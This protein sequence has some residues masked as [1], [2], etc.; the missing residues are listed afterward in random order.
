MFEFFTDWIADRALNAAF[1]RGYQDG[2]E[3]VH[4]EEIQE[5]YEAGYSMAFDDED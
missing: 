2:A 1:E 4:N 5:S 3:F